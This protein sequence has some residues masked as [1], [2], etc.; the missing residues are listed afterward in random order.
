V[1]HE[2]AKRLAIGQKDR[3]VIEAEQPSRRHGPN[4]GTLVQFDERLST[5]LRA[6]HRH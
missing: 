3:E 4:T 1:C 2:P 5:T 6:E